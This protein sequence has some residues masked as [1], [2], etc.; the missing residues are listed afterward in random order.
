MI[1]GDTTF[2]NLNAVCTMARTL[3]FSAGSTQVVSG[4][5]SLNGASK[6]VSIAIFR[7][8]GTE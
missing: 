3:I 5:L 6:A 2:S 1:S 4:L 8:E 7:S